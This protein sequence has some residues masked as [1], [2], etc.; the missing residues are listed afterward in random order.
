MR[1]SPHLGEISLEAFG[2]QGGKWAH[3]WHGGKI[4]TPFPSDNRSPRKGTA[5]AATVA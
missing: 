2:L 4:S 3:R 5:R 1:Q